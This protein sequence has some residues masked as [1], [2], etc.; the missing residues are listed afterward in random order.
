SRLD[1]LGRAGSAALER[2]QAILRFLIRDPMPVDVAW[3]YASSGG[4]LQD[5]QEL[6]E[7]GLVTLSESETWR[8]PLERINVDVSEPPILT[9][10]QQQ[11]WE[12]LQ[13]AIQ[14]LGSGLPAPT[15]FLLHGITGSGKT[16]VYM[17]AV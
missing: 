10:A 2:R 6:E 15:P 4:N 9:A 13:S 12:P 5:L 17:R 3:V 14:R 1:D 11:A 16:E 8:D 7:F